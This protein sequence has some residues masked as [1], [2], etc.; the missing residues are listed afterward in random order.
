MIINATTGTGFLGAISYIHKEHEKDFSQEQMPK[1]LEEN[2][3]FGTVPEQAYLMR[4]IAIRMQKVVVQFYI[5][6]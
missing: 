1:I 4:S 2:M 6:R 3:V 5:Y